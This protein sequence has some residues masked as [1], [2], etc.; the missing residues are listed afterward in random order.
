M[1]N[2]KRMKALQHTH[3]N[4]DHQIII[5]ISF[6]KHHAEQT[7]FFLKYMGSDNFWKTNSNSNSKFEYTFEQRIPLLGG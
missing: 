1:I 2:I 4:K 5:I 7:S 3:N 6:T